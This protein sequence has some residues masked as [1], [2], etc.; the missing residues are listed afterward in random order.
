MLFKQ[1]IFELLR[2]T[3][4]FPKRIYRHLHFDGTINVRVGSLG[5]FRIHHYGYQVENDLFW[6]GY[7]EGWEGTSLRL[8]AQPAGSARTIFDIGANTGVYALAAKAVNSEAQIFAFEPAHKIA[9]RLKDNISLNGFDIKVIESGVSKVTGEVSFYEPMA[10]HSYSASINPEMLAGTS[11]V[12]RTCIPVTRIDDYI[13]MQGLK[14]ADLFKI[15]VEKHEVEVLSGFGDV[16][17]NFSPAILIEILD[18][19]FGEKV[20][21]FFEGL[22]YVFF[23]IIVQRSNIYTIEK[24]FLPQ[25]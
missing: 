24:V 20:E 25:E 16:I 11:N 6:A 22:D 5:A 7:G 8:W 13:D 19:K 23:E 1:P 15:D 3:I 10:E 18:R 12:K 9:N 4:R 17:V 14:S 21:P 2:R